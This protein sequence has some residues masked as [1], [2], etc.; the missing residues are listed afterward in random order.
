MSNAIDAVK[1]VFAGLTRPGAQF[2]LEETTIQGITYRSYKNA[3]A[4]L[5]QIYRD[6]L[7]FGEQPFLVYEDRRYTFKEA[8]SLASK[9]ASQLIDQFD[10]KKGDRVAIAMRNLPEWILAFMG[11]TSAGAIAVPLKQLGGAG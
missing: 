8:Y 9:V 5:P 1:T 6:S 11:V 3:P 2:E 7:A 10:I 4:T